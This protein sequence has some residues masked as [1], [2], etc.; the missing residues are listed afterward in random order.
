MPLRWW[1]AVGLAPSRASGTETKWRCRNMPAG[2]TR[3]RP[4]APIKNQPVYWRFFPG[5]YGSACGQHA[6]PS[7]AETRCIANKLLYRKI[8]HCLVQSQ[9]KRKKPCAPETRNAWWHCNAVRL[10]GRVGQRAVRRSCLCFYPQKSFR[11]RHRQRRRPAKPGLQQS[12][13]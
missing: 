1:S 12:G 7:L 2:A 3:P 4:P 6:E 9:R 13:V 8:S 10:V 11:K 5:P